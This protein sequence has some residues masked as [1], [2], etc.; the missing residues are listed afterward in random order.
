MEKKHY[1]AII[2]HALYGLRDSGYIKQS[3]VKELTGLLHSD[4]AIAQTDKKSAA[5]PTDLRQKH[6]IAVPELKRGDEQ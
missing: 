2:E 5:E 6:K 1:L 4:I 3:T